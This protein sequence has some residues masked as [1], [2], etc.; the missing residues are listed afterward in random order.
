M[1]RPDEKSSGFEQRISPITGTRAY[2][3]RR[4]IPFGESL[5]EETARCSPKRSSRPAVIGFRHVGGDELGA[6]FLNAKQEKS[7]AAQAIKLAIT[8]RAA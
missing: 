3:A 5:C 1:N 8:S 2:N 6:S 7:V 4:L